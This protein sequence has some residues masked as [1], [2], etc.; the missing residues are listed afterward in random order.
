MRCPACPTELTAKAL[1][2]G[3]SWT[4]AACRGVLMRGNALRLHLDAA[5]M[6]ELWKQ[7]GAGARSTHRACPNCSAPFHV[8]ARPGAS[9]AIEL[10]ACLKCALIWFDGGEIAKL[11]TSGHARTPSGPR[12]SEAVPHA[13]EI[14]NR[15]VLGDAVF[16]GILEFVLGSLSP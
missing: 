6:E 14:S 13:V 15:A 9:G 3:A 16:N 8:W 11:Q 2:T 12:G 7:A 10:D 1:E 4:C 5:A